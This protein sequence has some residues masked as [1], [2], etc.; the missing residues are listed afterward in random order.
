MVDGIASQSLPAALPDFYCPSI[1][2]PSVWNTTQIPASNPAPNLGIAAFWTAGFFNGSGFL[3]VVTLA[4]GQVHVGGPVRSNSCLG[5]IVSGPNANLSGQIADSQIIAQAAMSSSVFQSFVS[6]HPDYLAIYNIGGWPLLADVPYS[7]ASWGMQLQTCGIPESPSTSDYVSYLFNVSTGSPDPIGPLSGSFSCFSTS[8]Q[9]SF[10]P[11]SV[12]T[13]HNGATY[14]EALS[15]SGSSGNMS[16][17]TLGLTS[18]MYGLKLLTS[19]SVPIS[20]VSPQCGNTSMNVEYCNATI[21][22]WYGVLSIAGGSI[23]NEW[24]SFSG[25]ARWQYSNGLINLNLGQVYTFAVVS[26]APVQGSGDTLSIF[27]LTDLVDVS[28]A[29]TL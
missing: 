1:T 11:T 14:R 16:N 24:G 6:A 7:G 8:Y 10:T 4:N 3:L 20:L 26:A 17:Y 27:P 13:S 28:G 12:G 2:G 21:G 23:V 9:L 18:W 19:E 5:H 15:V 22:G 25:T 29:Q